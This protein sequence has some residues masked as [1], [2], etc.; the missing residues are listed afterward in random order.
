MTTLSRQNTLFVAEDWVRI[1]DAIQ[2]VDF[3]AYDQPTLTQAILDY[4]RVNY[5]E[6]FNDWTASSEFVTKVEILTWLSQNIAF[7]VDMNKRENLLGVAERREAILELAYNIAYKVNRVRGARGEVKLL[8]IRTDQPIVDSN[9]TQLQNVTINWNDPANEDWYEQFITVMNK[10]FAARTQYGK[11]LTRYVDGLSKVEQYMFNSRAPLTGVYAFTAVVNGVN[12]NFEVA[13]G[14]LDDTTGTVSELAPV[15]TNVF[16]IFYRADGRGTASEGTGFFLPIRQGTLSSFEQ[17]IDTPEIMRTVT[18]PGININNDDLFVQQIDSSGNVV[19]TWTQVDTVFGEGIGFNTLPSTTSTIF[20]AQT[21]AEDQVRIRFGDGKFADIPVGIFKFWYRTS[22]P[23]PFTIKAENI[24]QRSITL[25]YVNDGQIYYI[26]LTFSLQESLVNASSSESNF[27]IKTRAASVI[28]AQNRMITGRDYNAFILSDNSIQKATVVNR[29]FAGHSRYA[30]LHDPTGMYENIKVLGEDGRLYITDT[31]SQEYVSGNTDVLSNDEIVTNYVKPLFRK[32]DKKVLYYSLYPEQYVSGEATFDVTSVVGQNS[33]GVI[34]RDGDAQEVG[35]D[36]PSNDALRFVVPDAAIRMKR[37][38]GPVSTVAS[39]TGDGTA[40]DA[41]ILRNKNVTDGA[42]VISVM[43]PMRNIPSTTEIAA[44]KQ[45][46]SL[47]LTF[48]MS[49]NQDDSEWQIIEADDLDTE[50]DFDLTNQGDTT[51]AALDAS[52]LFY[53]QFVPG[54][55][56][57]DDRWLIVD[58]GQSI[59][60]ESAAE[61][62]FFFNNEGTL[63]NDPETGR[64]LFDNV[65]VLGINESKNSLRRRNLSSMLLSTCGVVVYDFIGDGET[66]CFKTKETP[67]VAEHLVVLVDGALVLNPLEYSITTSASGDSICF[68]TAPAEGAS[69]E[70]RL[71][72]DAAYANINVVTEVSD[73][74]LQQFALG[75]DEATPNNI[76]SSLSAVFQNP[77]RDYTIT[78]IDGEA[79]I[80]Y[81]AAVANGV[82]AIAHVLG[83]VT[84]NIFVKSDYL[85]DGVETEFSCN[86]GDQ[87]TDSVIVIIDGVMQTPTVDFTL[88]TSDEDDTLIVFPSAVPTGVRVVIYAAQVPAL[89]RARY[90]TFVGDGVTTLFTLTGITTVSQYQPIVTLDG[91]HQTGPYAGSPDW[92]I[93]NNN[94]I[95]FASAPASGVR[96]TV[97]TI[98]GAVGIA[99][100]VNTLIGDIDLEDADEDDQYNV[101]SC[102]VSYMGQDAIWQVSDVLKHPDGYTNKN[103]LRIVP[104]DSDRS[105]T[106]DNPFLFKDIVLADGVTDLV[107]WRRQTE[108]GY[109]VWE[110]INSETTPKGT[111]GREVDTG[112]SEGEEYDVEVYE[113]GDI[114]Y[115]LTSQQWLVA[116][117]ES[118]EWEAADDQTAYKYEIG[119]DLLKFIWTHYSTDQT[120]I[121]PSVTNVMDAYLLIRSYY[122]AYAAWIGTNGAAE[123]EP[124]EPSPETLRVQYDSFNDYKATN[125][126]LIFH[127]ARLKPLFGAKADSA[128]QATFKVIKSSGS[129]ISDN[130]LR[131]R[132]LRAIE[133]YF[134]P[135]RWDFGSSFYF[136]E[137]VAYVHQQVAPDMQSMVIVPKGDDQVFGRLFQIRSEPDELF[138]S[139]AQPDDIE[140]VASFT[141]EELRIGSF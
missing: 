53:L 72:D 87:T 139:A 4:V 132:I 42:S 10:A 131:L 8:S 20:E 89:L 17:N 94:R 77:G 96:V 14:T 2:N 54:S 44:I 32:E 112:I 12:L 24:S 66:T 45:Q 23:T 138:I 61:I 99:F 90:H 31:L 11:P 128:L 52:W 49:W 73:G 108:F 64:V 134:D 127:A 115:D 83:D 110:P 33:R 82:R 109:S 57:N 3:R 69:I 133:D 37:L 40:T 67:L 46:L 26:T 7:R 41:I 93:N 13:N 59:N 68:V 116:D 84:S 141:D 95:Q 36:A 103:G 102:F 118:G 105:G 6:E 130:D 79:A 51:G 50:S 48:G 71:S 106:Y 29:T 35:D 80:L 85:A 121:D 16:N 5:P 123:D 22:N 62:D 78:A 129:R 92:T 135:N 1:Y 137:L 117:E 76:I 47:Q 91:L 56:G 114:H 81:D 111:F 63:I 43:P 21:L 65:K 15:P 39:V 55:G 140:L 98:L 136:T 120:R 74:T 70:V 60:W 125:D 122:D 34:K 100:D 119:R 25:P 97:F 107:L 30:K 38:T 9:D 58:R 88:D 75:V 126:S 124:E 101:A 86:V 18:L 19:E 104:A 113:D 27:D 28:Y